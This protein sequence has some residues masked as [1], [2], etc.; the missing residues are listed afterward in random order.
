M[1]VVSGVRTVRST[2]HSF[3]WRVV[4]C[5]R[6][7]DIFL[8]FTEIR[9]PVHCTQRV[10]HITTKRNEPTNDVSIHQCAVT[11]STLVPANTASLHL[12]TSPAPPHDIANTAARNAAAVDAGRWPAAVF[13][14]VAAELTNL[15]SGT[16]GVWRAADA[17][18]S[19]RWRTS[20]PKSWPHK[21]GGAFGGWGRGGRSTR[22]RRFSANRAFASRSDRR[23]RCLHT[24]TRVRPLTSSC[25]NQ[26]RRPP[27]VPRPHSKP[28]V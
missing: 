15:A 3:T 10:E 16:S 18:D 26:P 6:K 2:K 11:R 14:Y 12:F 22:P 19:C 20:W 24:A 13:I 7:E 8:R 25:H 4:P 23:H 27:T 1:P 9:Q 5:S 21:G 28:E 17:R